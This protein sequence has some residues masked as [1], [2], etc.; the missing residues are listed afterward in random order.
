[1]TWISTKTFTE[2]VH[3]AKGNPLCGDCAGGNHVSHDP[4]PKVVA[5]ARE[6]TY[7]NWR[8]LYD[9]KNLF[10]DQSGAITGQCYCRATMPF[11]AF[12]FRCMVQLGNE[13]A[14]KEHEAQQHSVEVF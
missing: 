14:V 9:C 12:C 6:N 1:M 4:D 7:S 10:A 2:V 11:D 13:A 8:D 3:D 5:E